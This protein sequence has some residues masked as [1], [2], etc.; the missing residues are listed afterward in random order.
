MDVRTINTIFMRAQ[1]GTP[2][3]WGGNATHFTSYTLTW[4]SDLSNNGC[5][6]PLRTARTSNRAF[7][8]WKKSKLWY[9]GSNKGEKKNPH[10]L[11]ELL[12]PSDVIF[13]AIYDC[14]VG[15]LNSG[16]RR[17]MKYDSHTNTPAAIEAMVFL[18]SAQSMLHSHSPHL[19]PSRNPDIFLN[20]H[21]H[22]ID[23]NFRMY[24]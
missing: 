13:T 3:M 16:H 17:Y 4:S 15:Q 24:I 2:D 8:F 9:W 21:T 18:F 14:V 11:S 19:I 20:T 5:A 23:I 1:G 12:K 22:D 7:Q 10:G 6:H